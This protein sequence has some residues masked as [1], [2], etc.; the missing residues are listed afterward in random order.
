MTWHE[1]E[2]VGLSVTGFVAWAARILR[3]CPPQDRLRLFLRFRYD[4]MHQF[5]P[6]GVFSV[7]QA[8]LDFFELAHGHI[9]GSLPLPAGEEAKSEYVRNYIAWVKAARRYTPLP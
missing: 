2:F 5:Y 8:S 4:I 7:G 3:T 9:D 6:H 1:N